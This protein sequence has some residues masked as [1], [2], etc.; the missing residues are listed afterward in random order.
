MFGLFKSND[1]EKNEQAQTLRRRLATAM[2]IH[3]V[4]SSESL[5]ISAQLDRLLGY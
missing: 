5:R 1:R 3:G 2:R 4:N